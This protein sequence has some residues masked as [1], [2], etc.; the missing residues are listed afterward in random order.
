MPSPPITVVSSWRHSTALE[1]NSSPA[2]S[3]R[4]APGQAHE[5]S[6]AHGAEPADS[7]R[8][9]RPVVAVGNGGI[10]QAALDRRRG[11]LAHRRLRPR[12]P[13]AGSRGAPGA[14]C[15]GRHRDPRRSP[16]RR[17]RQRWYPAGDARRPPRRT[18][19]QTPPVALPTGGLAGCATSTASKPPPRTTAIAASQ[20]SATEETS[21]RHSSAFEADPST[22]ALGRAVLVRAHKE[23]Q[24]H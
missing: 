6:R 8:G 16:H 18:G 10:Q 24:D 3:G 9:I 7:S 4:A 12:H 20:P 5:E 23:R 17:R 14:R 15:Q 13:R 21:Q 1:A 22:A 2:A 19:P 11:G